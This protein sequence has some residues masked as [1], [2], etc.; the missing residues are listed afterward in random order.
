MK[1]A[2]VTISIGE[3][4]AKMAKVTHKTL[5]AYADKI[6]AEFIVLDKAD[7]YPHWQKMRLY[8]L[9][10]QYNRIIYLDIDII[11]RED[12]PNLFELIP[13]TK[14]GI[15]NEGR[16]MSREDSLIEACKAYDKK[17]PKDYDGTYYNTGVM[18]VSRKHR[19]LFKR[20]HIIHNLGMFEQGYLNMKILLDFDIKKDVE[21]L[22][23]KFNRMTGLD[24]HCG[25]HR[26]DSYIVHYAGAPE[27]VNVPD[28]MERDLKMWEEKKPDYK[29]ERNIIIYLCGG[30]GD[31]L[32]AEPVVRFTM[33]KMFKDVKTNYVILS[34]WPRL[35]SHLNV[36]CMVRKDW[37]KI[38]K[39]DIPFKT[40]RTIPAPGEDPIWQVWSHVCGHTV[41]YAAVSSIHKT[42]PDVDKDIKLEPSLDGLVEAMDIAGGMTE[43]LVLIHPG[44]GWDSKTFPASWWE[45]VV[46]GLVKT[47][48][49]VG[50][51]GKQVNEEQGYVDINV[52]EG[53]IDFRDLLSLDGLISLIAT[54]KMVISNDSAPVH[55]AGAFDNYIILIATCKHP[56]HVLPYRHCNKYYKA[57][58]FTKKLTVDDWDLSPTRIF[59]ESADVVK[60]NILDYLPEPNDVINK[61]I[62]FCSDLKIPSENQGE[63]I[64]TFLKEPQVKKTNKNVHWRREETEPEVLSAF[65]KYLNRGDNVIDVGA[66]VGLF[67]TAL[68][69]IVP[70]G[71]VYAFEM[72]ES[73]CN[74]LIENTRN[75]SNVK[76]FQN[77]VGD[78]DKEID[79]YFNLDGND[80]HALWDPANHWQ[81][82]KTKEHDRIKLKV[83][84]VKLDSII[85]FIPK[86]IKIDV[87]GCELMVLKGAERLL[88]EYKPYIVSEVNH[89]ALKEMG[90]NQEELQNYMRSF[91]YKTFSLP[92]EEEIDL[93]KINYDRLNLN[94]LFKYCE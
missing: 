40:I 76:V 22:D 52:P 42:I 77:A 63:Q 93:T 21:E 65:K 9:L 55:I 68:I 47:G 60:G 8:D 34:D 18:V 62:E 30:M 24:K 56:D 74:K 20:P 35:F 64:K 73:N 41:D 57:Y 37:E 27:A 71:M 59:K 89:M 86:L 12:C 66:N 32:A 16:F 26:L 75:N 70:D 58:A 79:F 39:Y 72:E 6:G 38:P 94:V 23:Y 82:T 2:V 88:K 90:T 14:L 19:E 61:A 25:I 81:N 11:I 54:A 51:I 53:V 7:N 28:L 3:R 87:E 80:G 31:Q 69:D 78:E 91:G 17:I 49:R 84:M 13:E 1:Q 50:I 33:E 92:D 44:R 4:F 67:T 29:F 46:N 48:K 15:F 43:D 10:I 85:D 36:P 5:K 45:E 83:N